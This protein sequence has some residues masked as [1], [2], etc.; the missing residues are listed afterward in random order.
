MTY[1]SFI[2]LFILSGMVTF[3]HDFTIG[4]LEV[5][6]TLQV[7]TNKK[8]RSNESDVDLINKVLTL[9]KQLTKVNGNLFN[10]T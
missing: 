2:P 4:F 9:Y 6:K 8:F 1:F 5:S 10:T 3:I 7:L